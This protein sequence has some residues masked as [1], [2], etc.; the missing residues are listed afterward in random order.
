[1]LHHNPQCWPTP[2]RLNV[3]NILS[4]TKALPAIR[5][6]ADH[7]SFAPKGGTMTAVTAANVYYIELGRDGVLRF[8]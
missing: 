2:D 5:G 7:K 1:M 4:A 3:L 8:G 6:Q